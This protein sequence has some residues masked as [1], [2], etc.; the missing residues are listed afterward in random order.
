MWKWHNCNA[1]VLYFVLSGV[2]MST[3][4]YRHLYRQLQLFRAKFRVE[5]KMEWKKNQ[6]TNDWISFIMKEKLIEAVLKRP[7][8]THT[9]S[10]NTRANAIYSLLISLWI[11]LSD[12]MRKKANQF[13]TMRLCGC[14]KKG[15]E[16]CTFMLIAWQR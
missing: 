10:V 5:I 3:H 11:K 14:E 7:P 13:Q 12:E 9:H 4:I 15:K 2:E 16:K 6:R 8:H 1:F